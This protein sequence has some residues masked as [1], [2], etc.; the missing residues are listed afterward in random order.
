MTLLSKEQFVGLMEKGDFKVKGEII[1]EIKNMETGP[2]SV[3]RVTFN[4][5]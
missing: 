2:R 1:E 4:K 3:L 5:K